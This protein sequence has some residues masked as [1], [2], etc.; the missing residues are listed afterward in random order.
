MN[1]KNLINEIEREDQAIKSHKQD[2]PRF[3]N[4]EVMREMTIGQIKKHQEFFQIQE[5]LEL[6]ENNLSV[7]LIKFNNGGIKN[8]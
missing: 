2:K 3:L 5:T 8:E 7:C 4:I 1:A 6:A